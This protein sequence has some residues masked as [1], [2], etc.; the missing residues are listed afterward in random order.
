MTFCPNNTYRKALSTSQMQENVNTL[1][2]LMRARGWTDNA[3]SAMLGNWESECTINPNRPQNSGYPTTRTG[4]FGFA[5]WTPWGT[6]IGWYCD[7]HGIGYNTSDTNPM[8][9]I[10]V[11]L[12][13][14]DFECR[15]GLQGTGRKTWYSNKGYNYT[16]DGFLKSTDSPAEL[17]RAYYWEYERSA[18]ADPGKRPSQA[19]Q[20]YSYITGITPKPVTPKSSSIVLLAYKAGV[21]G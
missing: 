20:W 8:S 18:A 17:A 14:H 11:Q 9:A 4:G 15:Y 21:I 1:L 19:E 7:Q 13:Y 3:I 2:P 5:Q 16:W 10:E 6:K 12:D